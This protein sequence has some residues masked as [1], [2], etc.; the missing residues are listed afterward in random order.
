MNT[1]Q[2]KKNSPLSLY[3]GR[4]GVTMANFVSAIKILTIGAVFIVGLYCGGWI[5]ILVEGL[6]ALAYLIIKAI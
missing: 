2:S 6:I 4:K 3:H 5:A 1:G